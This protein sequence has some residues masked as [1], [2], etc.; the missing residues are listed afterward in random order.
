MTWVLRYGVP[1][2]CLQFQRI[3]ESL[4]ESKEVERALLEK[5]G[6][7]QDPDSLTKKQKPKVWKANIAA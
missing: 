5:V 2:V 4:Q 7:L 6:G 3:E 1:R